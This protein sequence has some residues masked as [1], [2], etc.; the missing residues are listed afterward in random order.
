MSGAKVMDWRFPIR[1]R[2]QYEASF[3]EHCDSID[4]LSD[5]KINK[6]LKKCHSDGDDTA[7]RT[8]IFPSEKVRLTNLRD[9]IFLANHYNENYEKRSIRELVEIGRAISINL[10]EEEANEIFKLTLPRLKS[11]CFL[12]LRRG[13]ITGSTFKSCCIADVNDPSIITIKRVISPSKS[14]ELVPG[15]KYQIRNKKKAIQ[16][17]MRKA[18]LKHEDFVYSECGLIVNS[19]LPYFAGSPD[20]LVHCTCHGDGCLEVKCFNIQEIDTLVDFITRKP[21]N[22]FNKC[23]NNYTVEESHDLFYQL[24]L[25][26]NLNSSRYCD[27]L[28]WSP[29]KAFVVRVYP[30]RD[31]W[32]TAMNKAL[33]FHEQVVMPEL[34]A[35]FYT[36]NKGS[37]V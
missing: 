36:K 33:N 7:L 2:A 5:E 4:H 32:N 29:R 10:T 1:E 13:R 30:N 27:C 14:L 3:L 18:I 28:V 37:T 12:G 15:I 11:K 22:M 26:I 19:K 24:Q 25:Q 21:N 8:I 31:F 23:G 20:G 9:I 16:Q 6:F 35:K 34:L 17:Y